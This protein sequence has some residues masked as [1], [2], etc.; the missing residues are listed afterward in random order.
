M[1]LLSLKSALLILRVE[2]RAQVSAAM[3]AAK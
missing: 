1:W 3:A 2:K